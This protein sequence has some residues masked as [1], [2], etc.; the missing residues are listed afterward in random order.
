MLIVFV[1]ISHII[2]FAS[3]SQV[4]GDDKT[5]GDFWEYITTLF[6]YGQFCYILYVVTEC[7]GRDDFAVI[8]GGA[9][10]GFLSAI[11]SEQGNRNYIVTLP[12]LIGLVFCIMAYFVL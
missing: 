2:C 5:P 9:A 11:I 1:M 7:Q 10:I 4:M 6:Y 3:Y 12:N 8:C